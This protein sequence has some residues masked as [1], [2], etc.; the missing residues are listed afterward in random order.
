MIIIKIKDMIYII[1]TSYMFRLGHHTQETWTMAQIEG[2][3]TCSW[4]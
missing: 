1:T 4:E 3:E 2:A